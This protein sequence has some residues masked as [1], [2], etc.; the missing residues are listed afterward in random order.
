MKKIQFKYN[1]GGRYNSGFHH[2]TGDCVT[3]SLSIVLDIEYLKAT[4]YI[5]NLIQS[6]GD[7]ASNVSKGISLSTTKKLMKHFNLIWIPSNN[8]LEI[9]T[10]TKCILNVPLHV[11]A[12]VNGVINDT[13]DFR[14]K[15]NRFYGYWKVK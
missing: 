8:L 2:H 3:R 7:R 9:P 15:S 6:F 11:C 1:D 13:H 4:Q 14:E 12:M 10:R 5:N